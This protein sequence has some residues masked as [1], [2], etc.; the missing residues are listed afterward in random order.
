MS[1]ETDRGT[2]RAVDGVRLVVPGRTSGSSAS[3]GSGKSVLLRARWACCPKERW[4]IPTAEVTFAGI[5]VRRLSARR[6][7]WGSRVAM[8][9]WDPMTSTDAIAAHR[10]AAA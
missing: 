1:F 5:D 3:R 2:L 10:P 6:P 9:F 8:V 4:S 7:F